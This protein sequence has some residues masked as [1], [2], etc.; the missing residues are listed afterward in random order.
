MRSEAS[1]KSAA[2]NE[3]TDGKRSSGLRFMAL[4]IASSSAPGMPAMRALGATSGRVM[5]D[6]TISYAPRPENGSSP[7]THWYSKAA[8]EYWS[9]RK[10]ASHAARACSGAMYAAVPTTPSVAVNSSV[11]FPTS[12]LETPKSTSFGNARPPGPRVM[13]MFD[14]FKS[15]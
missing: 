10:E 13:Q 2:P 8:R 11:P 6:S 14:G 4:R 7:V 3:R 1:D 5:I 15:R 12:T 9:L